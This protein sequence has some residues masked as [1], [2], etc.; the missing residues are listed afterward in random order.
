MHWPVMHIFV[1]PAWGSFL[2]T[3]NFDTYGSE[4]K[5]NFGTTGF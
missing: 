5:I 4:Q 3:T 2:A 1:P